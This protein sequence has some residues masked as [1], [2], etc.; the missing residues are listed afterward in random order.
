MFINRS[1]MRSTTLLLGVVIV[2]MACNRSPAGPVTEHRLRAV[3]ATNLADNGVHV[4]ATL[5]VHNDS[6]AAQLLEYGGCGPIA[7]RVYRTDAANA[8]W[9]SDRAIHTLCTQGA[10]ALTIASGDS[11]EFR[12]T[13]TNT[14]ILGDSLPDGTYRF[15]V[16]GRSLNPS[17]PTEIETGTLSLRR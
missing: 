1:W 12:R 4:V 11:H 9:D 17:L 6:S 14:D 5:T 3:A 10:S 7:V 15:T 16:S 13:L 2:V 8:I